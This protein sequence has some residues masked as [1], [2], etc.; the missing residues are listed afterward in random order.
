VFA[1]VVAGA[2]V[3]D[4]NKV[5][6]EPLAPQLH[7]LNLTG[8][9]GD[10]E[11]LSSVACIL[12]ATYATIMWLKALYESAT[13][14]PTAMQHN[15]SREGWPP[16]PSRSSSGSPTTT[17]ILSHDGVGAASVAAAVVDA[18]GHHGFNYPELQA[19]SILPLTTLRE[20]A[21]ER[22]AKLWPWPLPYS[23]LNQSRFINIEHLNVDEKLMFTAEDSHTTVSESGR[24]LVIKFAGVYP[25]EVGGKICQVFLSRLVSTYIL[26][27]RRQA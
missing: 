22:D 4:G 10:D 23:L 25:E 1:A 5:V 13:Q 9:D 7:L 12:S 14:E 20:A 6:C 2:Y 19:S 18:F 8:R 17:T 15:S 11:H 16:R 21:R 24:R 26:K 3:K 27:M